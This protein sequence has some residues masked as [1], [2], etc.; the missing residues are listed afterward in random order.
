MFTVL[1]D[2]ACVVPEQP[3]GVA[4]VLLA[5]VSAMGDEA[6]VERARELAGEISAAEANLAAV[7]AEVERR[8]IHSQ[9]ECRSVERF[10]GWHL[11]ISPARTAAL[12]DVGRSMAELPVVA[13][14]VSDGTLSFD[15]ATSV[16]RV[17]APTTEKAL[18]ELAL[19]ATVGQTRRICGQ[20]RKVEHRDAPD[21]TEEAAEHRRTL[22]RQRPERCRGR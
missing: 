8:G 7:L 5:G 6:L 3:G 19:H 16:A 10:T 20:W 15:K 13:E 21:G 18:V 1:V 14:A 9:W 2:E 11:Q 4:P 17:A 22:C 12:L